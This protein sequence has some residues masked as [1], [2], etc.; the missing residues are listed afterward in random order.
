MSLPIKPSTLPQFLQI[1]R[2][3]QILYLGAIGGS[4]MPT[5]TNAELDLLTDVLVDM[6]EL[7]TLSIARNRKLGG[8][9]GSQK[10]LARFVKLVGRN[11][12]VG[13]SMT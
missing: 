4:D 1:F 9:G 12:Q 10:E 6:K 7:H 13:L 2:H 5:M 11:C 8:G 3:I